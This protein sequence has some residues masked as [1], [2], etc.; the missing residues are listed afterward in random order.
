MTFQVDRPNDFQSMLPLLDLEA[1]SEGKKASSLW[2]LIIPLCCYILIDNKSDLS[3][4]NRLLW[5]VKVHF[6]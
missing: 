3:Y 6:E 4:R 1:H 2:Q 5:A